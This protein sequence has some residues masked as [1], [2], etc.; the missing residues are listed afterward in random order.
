MME[1]VIPLVFIKTLCNSTEAS[2]MA[3]EAYTISAA[4]S[5]LDLDV[6]RSAPKKNQASD[7][8]L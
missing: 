1:I 7:M 8:F 3:Q 5:E 4:S 2:H 6:D